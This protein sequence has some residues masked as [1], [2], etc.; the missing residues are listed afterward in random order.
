M[1]S[2]IGSG[3]HVKQLPSIVKDMLDQESYQSQFPNNTP[4]LWW[5]KKYLVRHPQ[6]A[7]RTLEFLGYQRKNFSKG[8]VLDWFQGMYVI[9]EP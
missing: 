8:E 9:Y 1:M 5:V 2:R 3:L 7:R 6:L 4:S